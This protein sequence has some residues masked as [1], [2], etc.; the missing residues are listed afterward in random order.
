MPIEIKKKKQ[1]EIMG[2]RAKFIVKVDQSG[3]QGDKHPSND[4][5]LLA[6]GM[7]EP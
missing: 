2:Q 4:V 3:D 6:L 5:R 1:A 7:E